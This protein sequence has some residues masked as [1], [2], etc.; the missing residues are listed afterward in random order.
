[1]KWKINLTLEIQNAFATPLSDFLEGNVWK[2]AYFK[3]TDKS[4]I[5]L[6][7]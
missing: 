7:F 4:I 1:M 3:I 6:V 2:L 5:V